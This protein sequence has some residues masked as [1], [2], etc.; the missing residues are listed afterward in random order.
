[1]SDFY[2][3]PYVHYCPVCHK[4]VR[5]DVFQWTR[6]ILFET[7]EEIKIPETL[8]KCE[9]GHKFMTSAQLDG[10]LLAYSRAVETF[11]NK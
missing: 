6:T 10:N 5:V 3:N 7:G 1:M 8:S 11:V 4:S 2:E 9:F